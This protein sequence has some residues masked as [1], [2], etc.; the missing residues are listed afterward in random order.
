MCM[1]KFNVTEHQLVPEHYLVPEKEE[2]EILARYKIDK[3]R[4]PKIRKTDPAIL[5]LEKTHGEIKEKR[6]IRIVRTSKTAGTSVVYRVVVK[7]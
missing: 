7:G 6:L 3:E 4:L 2:R 1:P 5:V